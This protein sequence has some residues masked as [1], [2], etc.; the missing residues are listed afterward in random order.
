MICIDHFKLRWF[1]ITEHGSSCLITRFPGFSLLGMVCIV[2]RHASLVHSYWALFVFFHF[3]DWFIFTGHVL[4]TSRFTGSF[5]LLS[6]AYIVSLP[7]QVHNYW[8]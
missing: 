1:I 6:M 5:Y 4:F 8:A 7:A 3:P 2:S